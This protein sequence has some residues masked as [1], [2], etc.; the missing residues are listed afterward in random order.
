MNTTQPI[1]SFRFETPPSQDEVRARLTAADHAAHSRHD[2][3]HPF[4]LLCP[5]TSRNPGRAR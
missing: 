5:S 2:Q 3:P 4:C 1:T